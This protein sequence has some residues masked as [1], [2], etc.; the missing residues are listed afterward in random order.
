MHTQNNQ[1]KCEG[2]LRIISMLLIGDWVTVLFFAAAFF[3]PFTWT[4]ENENHQV[5]STKMEKRKP[6]YVHYS[7]LDFFSREGKNE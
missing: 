1:R 3:L 5:P 6:E 4:V 7:E 2:E